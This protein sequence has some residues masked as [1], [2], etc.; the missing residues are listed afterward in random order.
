MEEIEKALNKLERDKTNNISIINFIKN[1]R[2]L[3]VE[4]IGNSVLMR[5]KSD[6]VWIYISCNNEDE[7]NMIKNKLTIDDVNFGAVDNWMVPIL[8]EGKKILWDIPVRQFYLPN[9]VSLPHIIY[10]TLPL[11][12]E[13]SKTI[14]DNYYLKEYIS[15]EYIMERI[16]KG[17]SVGIFENKNLVS[18]GITQDDGAI[19]FLHT[20][21]NFRRKGY[22][23]NVV[24]SMIDKLLQKG[25]L[26]FA[27][28]EPSNKNSINLF[29]KLGFK[30]NKTVHWFQ[31]K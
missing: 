13:D 17:V 21:H 4:I 23:Y 8:A 14:Y 1:N 11:T 29:L 2:L 22:G 18:W 16:R 3:S 5:G 7:L 26:P 6:H 28:I 19:G 30:E 20:L 27:Y 10:K 24:L 9:D 15:L 25:E 12:I 31:L